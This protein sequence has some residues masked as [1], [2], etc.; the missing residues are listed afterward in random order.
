[1]ELTFNEA[2]ELICAGKR[3]RMTAGPRYWNNR[4]FTADEMARLIGQHCYTVG[5]RFVEVTDDLDTI[6]KQS[7]ENGRAFIREQSAPQ[8]DDRPLYST[9]QEIEA[10]TARHHRSVVSCSSID[11]VR[12][13]R[14]TLHGRSF[15]G[16][17]STW[18]QAW[19]RAQLACYKAEHAR[20]VPVVPVI[21]MKHTPPQTVWVSLEEAGRLVNHLQHQIYLL[22]R[23]C[24]KDPTLPLT[25]V[26][27]PKIHVLIKELHKK[28]P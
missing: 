18:Q 1:M 25:Y 3:V 28:H 12:T 11:N 2:R 20:A 4:V 23:G 6:L 16:E 14:I 26:G 24:E 5:M 21:K 7:L 13:V 17:A 27:D 8:L 9:R 19:E 15:V 22:A 10:F